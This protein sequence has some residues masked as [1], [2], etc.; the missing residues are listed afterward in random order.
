MASISMASSSRGWSAAG[1]GGKRAACRTARLVWPSDARGVVP[2]AASRGGGPGLR[3]GLDAALQA[4]SGA[5]LDGDVYEVPP[6]GP[7]AVVVSYPLVAEE[8]AEDEPCVRAA[9]ADAAVRGH[10]L[11]GRDPLPTVE[12]LQLVGGLERSVVLHCA[13]PRDGGR[14][15]NVSPAL[16]ALLLVAGRRDQIAR[17]LSGRAHVDER[18]LFLAEPLVHL[19]A[20]RADRLVAL[21][22]LIGLLLGRRKIGGEVAALV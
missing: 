1:Q 12:L 16:R 2:P 22:R 3:P 5:F 7:R 17:V 9:L 11:V 14:G 13:R 4:A 19:V 20:I 8:L 6:L 18:A 10:F 15:G 21:L